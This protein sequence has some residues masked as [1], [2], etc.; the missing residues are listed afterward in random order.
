MKFTAAQIAEVLAGEV[1]GDPEV[2]VSQLA[3]IEQGEPGSLTFLANP[4]YLDYIYETKA[5]ICIV[6]ADFTPEK[7]IVPTL[8]RVEDSYRAFTRL[9]EYYDEVKKNKIGIE[10]PHYIAES[11]RYG[12][13]VYLGAFAYIGENVKIGDRVKI[14]PN[15]YVG[16]H[17]I[18]GDDVT[19]YSGVQI[20][21]ETQIGNN[22]TIHSNVVLGSDGFGYA[23][24]EKGVYKKI[25]QIGN[26]VVEDDVEIGAGTTI[27]RATMGSTLIKKGVK[28]D[29]QIQVAHN[30]IVD[31][32]TA[33]AAQ[34][35]IAGST[36]IGKHCVIGG[37]VGVA[38]HLKI[39]DQVKIQAQ[40]GINKNLKEGEVVQGS[41]ALSYHNY[42]K[43]YVHFK[44]LPEIEKRLRDVEKK[45]NKNG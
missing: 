7:E 44:N 38:G 12:A 32:H 43:S 45:L 23:P 14:Y 27:D 26:V 25:P 13:D 16:D 30:V 34:T 37:Q 28:L 42:N 41:P 4:K 18:I 22:C 40:T 3:K 2:E 20:Y 31:Q 24:D 10:T 9:L 36:K 5:S 21:R 15:V 17:A 29:N 35:G 11:A 1:E 8:I 33:I 6:N 19:I 39:N